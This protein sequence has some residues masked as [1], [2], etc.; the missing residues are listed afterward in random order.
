VL[1][2]RGRGIITDMDVTLRIPDEIAACFGRPGDVSRRAL[3]ALALDAYRE[4]SLSLFQVSDLLGL[5][6]VETED[7]L[8]KHQVELARIDT[9][10][11]DR[12][13]A[14]FETASEPHRR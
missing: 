14:I 6:R 10:E 7:L 3:E 4:G 9:S 12:E 13:A 8:G 2:L 1:G 5:S 11:L